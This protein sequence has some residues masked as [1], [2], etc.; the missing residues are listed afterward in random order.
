M[1]PLI[2]PQGGG[3]MIHSKLK[4]KKE[5]SGTETQIDLKLARKFYVSNQITLSFPL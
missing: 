4:I 5:L 3:R 2:N 1:L